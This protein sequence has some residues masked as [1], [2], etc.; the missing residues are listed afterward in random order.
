MK[1]EGKDRTGLYILVILSLLNSCGARD[2]A[3]KM[4]RVTPGCMEEPVG[5]EVRGE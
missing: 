3:E 4:C 2:Y 1:C 5:G